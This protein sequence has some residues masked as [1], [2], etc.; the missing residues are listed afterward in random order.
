MPIAGRPSLF[1]TCWHGQAHFV[2]FLDKVA[3]AEDSR[4]I[5]ETLFGKP[6]HF[7]QG[8]DACVRD[9]N[10]LVMANGKFA[11]PSHSYGLQGLPPAQTAFCET[12]AIKMPGVI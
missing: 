2:S 9:K 1:G 6:L 8:H 5:N 3:R 10:D 11:F 4:S 12:V 7:G